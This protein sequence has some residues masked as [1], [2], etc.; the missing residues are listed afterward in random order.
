MSAIYRAAILLIFFS[1][2]FISSANAQTEGAAI[3]TLAIDI[4]PDY[5]QASVLVLMT[6]A[7]L[8]DVSLPVS[9]TLPLPPGA[10]LNV[11]ARITDDNV[12]SDD[13][14][15]RQLGDSLIFD[16]PERRFRVEYYF[17]YVANENERAF[18]FTW[19]ADTAVNQLEV[20]VQ[21]PAS[22]TSLEIEPATTNITQ[23]P[24]DGL[25]YHILPAKSVASGEPFAVNVAYSM[26]APTL[27]AA[28]TAPPF[29]AEA[30]P[31]TATPSTGFDWPLL[32]AG[33]GLGLILAAVVWQVS[34]NRNKNNTKRPS[35]KA[36]KPKPAPTA[37]KPTKA[38][39]FCH[40]CG[41]ALKAT[42]QFCRE[43]GT[44]V[45]Q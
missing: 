43:C 20:A 23:D 42:D 8:D 45:K 44:A 13:V 25:T 12:M 3:D 41:T 17:P 34:A 32:L 40:E 37:T 14:E 6:G 15:F 38:A 2:V 31:P 28:Q 36:S 7:L 9:L 18:D 5:D 30:A 4:W 39:K 21:Q 24:N 33:L 29:A 1:F 22:A 19:L 27:T 16:S 26:A 11:V 10:E 35:K